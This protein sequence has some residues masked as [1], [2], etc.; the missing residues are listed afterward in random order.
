MIRERQ[1]P[2]GAGKGANPLCSHMI[3]NFFLFFLR[4]HPRHMEVPRLGVKWELQLPART[5]AHSNARS[6][7]H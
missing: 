5:T 3:S 4:L 7:T 2:L 6:L 1:V